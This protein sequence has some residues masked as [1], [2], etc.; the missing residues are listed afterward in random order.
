[1]ADRGVE[2]QLVQKDEGEEERRSRVERGRKTEERA[3][4][5]R[6]KRK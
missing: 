4:T 5:A 1:M 2:S 6:I 3:S